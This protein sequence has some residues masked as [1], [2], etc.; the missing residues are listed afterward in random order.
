MSWCR[1]Q[2]P[3]RRSVSTVRCSPAPTEI[4]EQL[5]CW[6]RR[7]SVAIQH[8][9]GAGVEGCDHLSHDRDDDD[10]GLLIGGSETFVE[11]FEGRVVSASAEAA[12]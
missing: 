4:N 1:P 6:L 3:P 10:L 7:I 12:M 2:H 9:R 8:C 11:G 5:C